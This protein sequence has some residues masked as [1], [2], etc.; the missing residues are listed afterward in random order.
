[1]REQ[2]KLTMKMWGSAVEVTGAEPVMVLARA[3]STILV[4]RALVALG[5][6]ALAAYAWLS[7]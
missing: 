5:L 6:T 4:L 1:M 2:R 3:I 7:Y